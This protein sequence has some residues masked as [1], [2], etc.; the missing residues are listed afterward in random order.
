MKRLVLATLLGVAAASVAAQQPNTPAATFP[1]II[2]FK[3]A[4]PL[5]DYRGHFAPDSRAKAMP[6]AW[7]YVDQ[8]VGGAVNFL[9][10]RFGFLARHVYSSAVAG[11]AAQL[12]A[13]QIADLE[14]D[15]L[16]AYVEPDGVMTAS[17][18]ILPWG[19]DR[20]NADT[21][22]TMAGNGV[23]M[24]SNVNVYV[25][26]TGIGT[27]ADL[28][29]SRHVTMIGGTNTDCHGHG[30]HVA[31]SVAA[32]DNT[33]DVVGVAPGAPLTGVKVL[34]CFGSGTTSGVIKGVDWVTANAK[35]PAVA[36][37]SLGG[38]AS[39]ALD[40]AVMRSVASGVV[41]TVAAGNEGVD[42]CTRSPARLGAN[43][44]VITIGATDSNNNDPSWSN[45]GACV[46]LW[47]PGD[48]I[49]S[50][51]LKGGTTTMSGTSMAAPHAAGAAALFLSTHT[52]L[53]PDLVEAQLKA[54]ALATGTLS[55]GGE[56]IQLIN[57]GG[58]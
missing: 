18:Q 30:T 10:K 12:N 34:D 36:N 20:I 48:S 21:S 58:Y 35:K 41:Y 57:V 47:A 22:S 28:N 39:Q 15:E 14:N 29:K 23:G 1:V 46:D 51:K 55:N 8:G 9:E 13:R 27:H 17:A 52:T 2:V 32:F 40:D 56:A 3:H 43:N 5:K 54:D 37:M 6:E 42:A 16:V 53:T 19:V 45:F 50:T 38:T 26:D 11:F 44:G 49:L 25:I 31:G 7:G 24:V 4:A 33:S